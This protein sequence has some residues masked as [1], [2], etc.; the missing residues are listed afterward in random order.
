[1]YYFNQIIIKKIRQVFNLLKQEI[2]VFI[3]SPLD[4]YTI[5][6]VAMFIIIFHFQCPRV[7][8]TNLKK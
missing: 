1:M 2:I 5:A 7:V 4:K 3:L 8:Q 6:Y